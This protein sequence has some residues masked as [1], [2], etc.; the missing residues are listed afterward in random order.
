MPS[1]P[2]VCF[3]TLRPTAAASSGQGAAASAQMPGTEPNSYPYWE[4]ALRSLPV[5]IVAATRKLTGPFDSAGHPPGDPRLG[6]VLRPRP[7]CVSAAACAACALPAANGA[8]HAAQRRLWDWQ[9]SRMQQRQMPNLQPRPAS[10]HDQP[11]TQYAD[12]PRLPPPAVKFLGPFS[13][14]TPSYLKGEYPGDYGWD[15]AGL[16][17]DPETFSR[18]RELEVIH[19]RWGE[20]P[21]SRAPAACLRSSASGRRR[22]CAAQAA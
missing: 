12:H 9:C 16:S 6:R 21:A 2:P 10:P 18:Y 3:F 4:P 1:A 8:S 20:Q 11:A 5:R 22:A 7:R 15:T 19:A 14:A 13:G 17:A